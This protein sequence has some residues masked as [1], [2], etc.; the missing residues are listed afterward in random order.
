MSEE[1][2]TP[3]DLVFAAADD[4]ATTGMKLVMR[5]SQQAQKT[6][7][8][9]QKSECCSAVSA[10]QFSE[11]RSATSVFLLLHVEGVGFRGGG[12]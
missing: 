3:R 11:N 4:L 1:R 12:V 9:L 5:N 2:E 8:A 10:A 6:T 7:S